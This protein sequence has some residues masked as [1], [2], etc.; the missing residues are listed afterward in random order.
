[1]T[2]KFSI[3]DL[4]K[5]YYNVLMI[6]ESKRTTMKSSSSLPLTEREISLLEKDILETEEL[7]QNLRRMIASAYGV[8]TF[9]EVA[10]EVLRYIEADP[11]HKLSVS[12]YGAGSEYDF[13]TKSITGNFFSFG[14]KKTEI[15]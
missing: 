9:A 8:A 3:K 1:M 12:L 14:N 4:M 11:Y 10:T 7:L 15:N 6:S 5:T 2:I 13:A